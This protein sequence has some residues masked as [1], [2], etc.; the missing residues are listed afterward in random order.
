MPA[1]SA[2]WRLPARVPLLQLL[3][4]ALPSCSSSP[5]GV[6]PDTIR[7]QWQLRIAANTGCDPDAVVRTIHF[8]VANLYTVDAGIAFDGLWDFGAP[9]V[10]GW[11]LSGLADPSTRS[12]TMTFIHANSAAMQFTGTLT[13]GGMMTGVFTEPTSG[14]E[15]LITI[16]ACQQQATGERKG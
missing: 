15:P 9:T 16:G 8:D 11:G 3:L 10:I 4:L 5:T 7:G 13:T 1:T 2:A 6:S 12:V 14:H